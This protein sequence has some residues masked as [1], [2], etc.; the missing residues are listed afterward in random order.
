MRKANVMK[1]LLAGTM[2]LT[3]ALSVGLFTACGDKGG[4]DGNEEDKKEQAAHSEF[5]DEIGGT[6]DTYKGSLSN[7]NYEYL[8]DAAAAFVSAEVS[9]DAEIVEVKKLKA[10]NEEEVSALKI[11]ASDKAI[12][13]VE[14]YE[15]SYAE[16]TYMP[17][18][19]QPTTNKKV[20]VYLIR[21][22]GGRW[23]Y[24]APCPVTGETIT[25]GY[26]DSVFNYEAYENCTYSNTMTMDMST[27]ASM[28]GIKMTMSMGMSL[29]QL[30]KYESGKIYMEQTTTTTMKMEAPDY[31]QYNQNE[32]ESN[33]IYAYLEQ[34]ED[35]LVCYAKLVENGATVQNWTSGSIY[36][37]GFGSVEELLPFADGYLDYTYFT[38]TDF[39]FEL[40]GEQAERYLAET[41]E[42]MYQ[43]Q[44]LLKD[45]DIKTIVKYYVQNGALTGSRQDLT[46]GYNG[47]ID[48]VSTSLGLTLVAKGTVKDYGT[49]VVEKPAE[50]VE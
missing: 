41:L 1:K 29:T 39:G 32:T 8:E 6:S 2:A 14:K 22:E 38:K 35:E 3:T 9:S 4:S 36:T 26:Y 20:V 50:I 45:M 18:S 21:Y 15:I 16:D 5:I 34:V 13:G 23:E 47:V 49:T 46:I 33:T 25:K 10:L 7:G 30:I 42:E 37:I 28:Q 43:Y 12:S 11:P 17:M 48:G 40:S 44:E 24:F 31:P 27:T 19:T